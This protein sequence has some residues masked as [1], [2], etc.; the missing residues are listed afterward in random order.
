[1]A[2]LLTSAVVVTK[3]DRR[4][5][6]EMEMGGGMWFVRAATWYVQVFT[7]FPLPRPSNESPHNTILVLRLYACVGLEIIL[8]LNAYY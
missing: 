3:I 1:M 4:R 5:D 6:K 2:A 7:L 8:A